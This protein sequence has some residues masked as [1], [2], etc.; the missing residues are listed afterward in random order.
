MEPSEVNETTFEQKR[1]ATSLPCRLILYLELIYISL[2]DLVLQWIDFDAAE[3][4]HE[5]VA[6]F[7]HEFL[8]LLNPGEQ[9]FV[10]R[11]LVCLYNPFII[12][13]HIRISAIV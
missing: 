4:T 7:F 9:E 11:T 1:H 10:N 8:S 12:T 5:P 6:S 2:I 13:S 3:F